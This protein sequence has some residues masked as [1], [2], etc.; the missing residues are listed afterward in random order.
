MDRLTLGVVAFPIL[1]VFLALRVPVGISLFLVGSGGTIFIAGWLPVLSQAKTSAFHLFSNYSLSVIPLFLLMGNFAAKA[2]MSQTLFRFTSA[3][4]GHFRG[5]AAMAAVGACAGFG[6]ICGSSVA[7]AA[8][9]GKVALPELKRLGYSG[10]LSTGSLAAGGTLGILI[11]PSVILIIYSILTE[12]NIAKMFTAAFLPGFIALLGYFATIHFVVRFRPDFG[13]RRAY[14]NFKIRLNLFKSIWKIVLIFLLVIGGIYFGWF[15]P[16]EGA[17]VGVAGTA[18]LAFFTETFGLKEF[19][20]V[21]EDTAVSAAMIFIVLLGAEFFNSFIALTQIT[22]SLSLWIFAQD[23][24]PYMILIFILFL[25]LFLGCMMDS[26]AM[27]M[28]TIPIFFPILIQLDFGMTV[29]ETAIW[30]GILVLVV[31]EIGLIT[32]PIGLNVFIINKLAKDV[33]IVETFKGVLPF[34]CSDICRVAL[35]IAFPAITL[36]FV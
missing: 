16:T 33:S 8:T 7:T 21:I 35:L 28:L 17:A 26:L 31:V 22:N 25:Y 3:C 4:L 15:T 24:S 12:Q 6:A 23:F 29:E 13:P 5:G 36:F 9:M 27:I 10:S 19:Q 14:V 18:L 2:G 20:D 30:F 11:P 32:P 1:F 34:V